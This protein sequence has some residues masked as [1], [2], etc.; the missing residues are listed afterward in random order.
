VY[1]GDPVLR[2]SIGGGLV[3]TTWGTTRSYD[4]LTY[5][6]RRQVTFQLPGVSF[7]TDFSTAFYGAHPDGIVD[8]LAQSLF[9]RFGDGPA[10]TQIECSSA[11]DATTNGAI[12]PGAFVRLTVGI[13]PNPAVAARGSTRVLQ[14]LQRDITPRG[15]AFRLLDA[16][17]NLTALAKPTIS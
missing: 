15:R 12:L 17:A 4:T 14:V 1:S 13:F 11:I 6:G 10:Y 3:A 7:L 8:R 5:F 9:Q 16:G 2:P